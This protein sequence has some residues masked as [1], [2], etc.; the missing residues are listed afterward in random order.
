MPADARRTEPLPPPL[1]LRRVTAL[2]GPY[3]SGK[4]ELALVLASLAAQALA[5]ASPED[6]RYRQVQLAD[7]DVLKPYFRSREAGLAMQAQGVGVL[8]PPAALAASDLPILTAEMRAAIADPTTR[9]ILDVGGDPTGAK[10][11][12]SLADVMAAAP[13]DLLLVLNRNRPFMDS[14]ERVAETARRIG[15]ASN[16]ALTGLVSNSHFLDH[17]TLDDVLG[18]LEFARRV[19]AALGIDVVLLGVSEELAPQ[20]AERRDLPPL[21]VVRRH[22]QPAFLGGVVLGQGPLHLPRAT[23]P[24]HPAAALDGLPP[25]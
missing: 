5:A 15:A 14:V 19:A 3:G 12:G 17:T 2:I 24:S 8:A 18:G 1:A 21:L 23:D 7:L 6:R 20:L 16:L 11:L 13:H 10:A 4:S 9:L 25:Q 22:L